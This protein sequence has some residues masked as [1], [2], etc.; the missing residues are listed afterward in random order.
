MS[1][2]IAPMERPRPEERYQWA[3][4]DFHEQAKP[5]FRELGHVHGRP[6]MVM[7]DGKVSSHETIYT[8]EQEA[9]RAKIN[10]MINYVRDTIFAGWGFD[11][12]GAVADS[13]WKSID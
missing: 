10:E 3:L 7:K 8:P 2:R 12:P 1:D 11:T 6:R 13:P 5:L 4:R 9:L